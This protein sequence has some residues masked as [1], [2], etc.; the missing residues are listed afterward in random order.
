M[1]PAFQVHTIK[2]INVF[3][4]APSFTY[5]TSAQLVLR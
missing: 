4:F 2:K 5:K 3:Q 1:K